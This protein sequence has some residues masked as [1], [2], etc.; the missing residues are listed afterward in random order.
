MANTVSNKKKYQLPKSNKNSNKGELRCGLELKYE[1]I[2][3]GHRFR[4]YPSPEVH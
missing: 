4:W 3:L 2:L 1:Y